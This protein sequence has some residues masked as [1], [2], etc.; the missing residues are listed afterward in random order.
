[1]KKISLVVLIVALIVPVTTHAQ[2]T[3]LSGDYI[4]IY[5]LEP[6]VYK[7]GVDF[8]SGEYEITFHDLNYICVI[9]YSNA[10]DDDGTPTLDGVY[11]YSLSFISA[12]WWQGA[13]INVYLL[14]G[15][16]FEVQYSPC[17]IFE[18]VE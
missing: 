14:Y 8:P 5:R 16:Y 13:R 4:G 9:N 7:I 3:D 10:L 15:D 6:G 12:N 17:T 18:I 1:M 2:V 11:S